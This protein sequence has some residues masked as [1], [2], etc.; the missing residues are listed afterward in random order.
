MFEGTFSPPV[1]NDIYN[2][3][4]GAQD[5]I[6][7][8]SYASIPTPSPNA[9]MPVLSNLSG[10]NS[11]STSSTTTT[12]DPNSNSCKQKKTDSQQ[13]PSLSSAATYHS[14]RNMKRSHQ[15]SI[16]AMTRRSRILNVERRERL[17]NMFR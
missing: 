13:S 8:D 5:D 9:S 10:T 2:F 12:S 15:S 1:Y 16:M 3:I 7:T 4:N 6:F 17:W 14:T 11:S